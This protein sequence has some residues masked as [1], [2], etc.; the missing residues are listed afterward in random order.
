MVQVRFAVKSGKLVR[1]EESKTRPMG[2]ASGV[3]GIS[4]KDE[5]DEVMAWLL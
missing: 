5:S 3:R 2:T 4:L 1:F